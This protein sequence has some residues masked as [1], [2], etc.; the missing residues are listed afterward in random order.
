MLVMIQRKF[1]VNCTYFYELE[2][3][4]DIVQFELILYDESTTNLTFLGNWETKEESNKP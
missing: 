3:I 4:N 2:K 1:H